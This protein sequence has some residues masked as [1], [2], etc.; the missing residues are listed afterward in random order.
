MHSQLTIRVVTNSPF[1]DIHK[2]RSL[3]GRYGEIPLSY[4][5]EDFYFHDLVD[6]TQNSIIVEHISNHDKNDH[7]LRSTIMKHHHRSLWTNE[8]VKCKSM[9]DFEG[10]VAARIR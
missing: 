8:L 10:T 1:A 3:T 4:I 7:G 6:L 2:I 5:N 9:A